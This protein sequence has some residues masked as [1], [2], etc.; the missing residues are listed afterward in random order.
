MKRRRCSRA[1]FATAFAGVML[2]QG[3]GP[4]HYPSSYLLNLPA[5]ALRTA[6]PN[7][8]LGTLAVR[9]FRCP[10]YLCEGRIVYRPNE[11][12]VG[13]YEFHRWAV[14]PRETITQFVVDDLRA[15]SIFQTVSLY[16]H[17]VGAAYVLSGNI[18]KLEEV[19][20][21]RDVQAVCTL[22]AQLIDTHSGSV[23]WNKTATKSIAVEP[24]NL[25]GVVNSL[26]AAARASVDQ[27]AESLATDFA[28]A[29][30]R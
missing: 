28:P 30:A 4:V 10:G 21:G 18:E 29:S 23:V 5:P 7:H 6:P 25:S 14:S 17:G 2:L 26:S 11:E 15:Q 27:L 1:W 20:R 12:E 9:E 24:R 22:F 8:F 19:D 16:E 3:C 13:Y